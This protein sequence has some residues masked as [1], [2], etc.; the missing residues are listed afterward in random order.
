MVGVRAGVVG[1]QDIT[2]WGTGNQP[3]GNQCPV[4]RTPI[5][6]VEELHGMVPRIPMAVPQEANGGGPGK[7]WLG[8]SRSM[9]DVQDINVRR[10][11]NQQL[12]PCKSLVGVQDTNGL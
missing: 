1:F 7:P 11:G 9:S 2:S 5:V 8:S 10:P 3:T 12:R 6:G 4:S